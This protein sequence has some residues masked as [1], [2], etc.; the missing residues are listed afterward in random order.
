MYCANTALTAR[1]S[2]PLRNAPFAA[3]TSLAAMAGCARRNAS[4]ALVA[5]VIAAYV[6]AWPLA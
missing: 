2:V 4:T 6:A 1:C 3:L 5:A